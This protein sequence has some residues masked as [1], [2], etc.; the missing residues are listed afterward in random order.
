MP[1]V[2]TACCAIRLASLSA[3]PTIVAAGTALARC[4]GEKGGRLAGP[5]GWILPK[6]VRPISARTVASALLAA[7]LDAKPGVRVLKSGAMHA[8]DE[9]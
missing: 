1:A 2:H 4:G 7:I 8:H 3:C 9:S 5:L 6:A